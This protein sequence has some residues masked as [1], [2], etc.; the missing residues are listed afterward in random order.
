MKADIDMECLNETFNIIISYAISFRLLTFFLIIPIPYH[1]YFE[2]DSI[3]HRRELIGGENVSNMRCNFFRYSMCS[4]SSIT[5]YEI[6][7]V[8]TVPI[9]DYD[10]S[11][12]KSNVLQLELSEQDN[13]SFNYYEDYKQFFFLLNY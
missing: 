1:Y 4:R 9:V 7:Y 6:E 11:E 12:T 5:Y 13:W 2:D 10:H 3:V 8:A